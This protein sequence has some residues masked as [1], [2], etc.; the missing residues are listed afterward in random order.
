[1][2][3]H[4]GTDES[5]N[6]IVASPQLSVAVAEPVQSACSGQVIAGPHSTVALAGQI[7]QSYWSHPLSGIHLS[8]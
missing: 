4:P 5:A 7:S 2:L 1:M 3:P 8:C 6:V